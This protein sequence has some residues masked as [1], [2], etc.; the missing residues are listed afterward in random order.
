MA[1]KLP[2]ISQSASEI[3]LKVT[4]PEMHLEVLFGFPLSK[5]HTATFA[6]VFNNF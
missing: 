3:T 4:D 2:Q 5:P 6:A 1:S